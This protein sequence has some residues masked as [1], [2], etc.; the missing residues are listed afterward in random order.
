MKPQRH[1]RL[2]TIHEELVG[3]K[4]ILL[5]PLRGTEMLRSS[6]LYGHLC[7]HTRAHRMLLV[8]K[9]WHCGGAWKVKESSHIPSYGSLQRPSKLAWAFKD[10]Q[11]A[12]SLSCP[13]TLIS[14]ILCSHPIAP[15]WAESD[16][17]SCK[18]SRRAKQTQNHHI[19]FHLGSSR[20][21]FK[22]QMTNTTFF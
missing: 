9:K 17:M 7:I 6:C 5:C 21:Q 4:C 11:N 8:R 16:H 3:S 1:I 14:D 22:K 2:W 18:P 15:P 19:T 13:G 10:S 12:A 20:S